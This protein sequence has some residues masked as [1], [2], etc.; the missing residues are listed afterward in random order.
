[1]NREFLKGLGL[2]D[3]AVENVMIEHG[4]TVNPLKG[5]R[6]NLIVE[7]DDLKTQLTDRDTQLDDLK[8]IDAA[9]MQDEIERLKGENA[10]A[11]TKM[12]VK[13]DAQAFSFALEKA[14]AATGARNPKAVRALLDTESVKLDG[15][16]L[17]GLDTQIEA[18]KT[19]DDYLFGTT[20]APTLGGRT[21]NQPPNIPGGTKNPWSKEH[22]N[23]TEQGRILREDPELAKQLQGQK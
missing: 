7:R 4:K 21:P 23:L 14:I 19:S 3:A 10:D 15:D 16:K 11:T 18:L 5:E 13:L 12:Q 22:L 9:G 17:L 1:M 8:K 2:D 6:D 20:E